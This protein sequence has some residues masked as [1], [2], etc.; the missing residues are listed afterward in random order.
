ML[1]PDRARGS[2]GAVRRLRR[3]CRGQ[4]SHNGPCD[5][6]HGLGSGLSRG[7]RGGAHCNGKLQVG[8]LWVQS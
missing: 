3:N 5:R 4:G 8:S 1:Y 6:A 7:A 2:V